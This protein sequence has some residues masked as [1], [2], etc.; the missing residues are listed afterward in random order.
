MRVHI[1]ASLTAATGNE[2]TVRRLGALFRLYGDHTVTYQDCN[3]VS[4][5]FIIKQ[6]LMK[7]KYSYKV[8]WQ[9]VPHTPLTPTTYTH[10]THP[11]L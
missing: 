11:P 3:S 10:P 8:K 9:Y 5:F 2:A 4:F 6:N 7:K 1:L